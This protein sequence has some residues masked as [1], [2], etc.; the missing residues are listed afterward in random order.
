MAPLRKAASHSRNILPAFQAAEKLVLRALRVRARLHRLLKNFVEGLFRVVLPFF[1]PAS[2]RLFECLSRPQPTAQ[3]LQR[4]FFAA[5]FAN[6]F[7]SPAAERCQVLQRR[8]ASGSMLDEALLELCAVRSSRSFV[9]KAE[10]A[11]LNNPKKSHPDDWS[12]WDF[13]C[14]RLAGLVRSKAP[15][16]RSNDCWLLF[17]L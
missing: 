13:A 9:T 11:N 16:I 2:S 6:S 3:P 7:A 4:D 8:A 15:R 5:W 14:K 10:R 1:R 12:G 17:R